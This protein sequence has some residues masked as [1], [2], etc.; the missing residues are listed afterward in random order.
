M[1]LPLSEGHYLLV[2]GVGV[3][4]TH[5][6]KGKATCVLLNRDHAPSRSSLP[7]TIFTNLFANIVLGAACLSHLPLVIIFSLTVGNP[8]QEKGRENCHA[9]EESRR[10]R[11][12]CFCFVVAADDFSFLFYHL[13]SSSI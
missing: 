5:A 7:N 10:V 12:M 4:P 3:E 8:Y 1:L 6:A 13:F 2:V 11:V 9:G